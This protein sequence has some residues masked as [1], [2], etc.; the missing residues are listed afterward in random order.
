MY[1]ASDVHGG[2]DHLYNLIFIVVF[3]IAVAQ[4]L[5]ILLTIRRERDIKE[6]GELVEEQR[7]HITELRAWLAGRNAAKALQSKS[8]RESMSEPIADSPQASEPEKTPQDLP[9][10]PLGVPVGDAGQMMKILNWQREIIAGLRAELKQTMPPQAA[11]MP[12]DFPA[13]PSTENGLERT[14]NVINWLKEDTDKARD[15]AAGSQ[16]AP[17]TKKIG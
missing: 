14:T 11:I 12:K 16:A 9:D 3:F 7:L 1:R 4:A 2:E 10:S 6:L 17:P 15:I 5:T 8:E 13:A